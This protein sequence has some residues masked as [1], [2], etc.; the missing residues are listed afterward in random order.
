MRRCLRGWVCAPKAPEPVQCLRDAGGMKQNAAACAAA[1]CFG[2]V[3]A[4]RR[5]HPGPR[6]CRCRVAVGPPNAPLQALARRGCVVSIPGKQ[7]AVGS[8]CLEH[9]ASCGKCCCDA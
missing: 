9:S 8:R 1:F 2:G 3:I 4:G 7:V 6:V 5:M